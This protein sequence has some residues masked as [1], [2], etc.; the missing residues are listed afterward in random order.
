[1]VAFS[2]F[3]KSLTITLYLFRYIFISLHQNL[4]ICSTLNSKNMISDRENSE[5]RMTREEFGNL[6][7]ALREYVSKSLLEKVEI[8]DKINNFN[9]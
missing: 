2:P 6:R 8:F 7:A 4:K 9:I 5:I 3:Y 1:M